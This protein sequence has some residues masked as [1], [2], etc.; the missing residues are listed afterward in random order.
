MSKT[1]LDCFHNMFPPVLAS[2]SCKIQTGHY[3]DSL[4]KRCVQCAQICGSHPAECSQYCQTLAPP[5]TFPVPSVL[6]DSSVL[7]YSLLALSIVLL[8]FSLSLALIVFLKGARAK[9]SNPGPKEANHNKDCVVQMGQ[10]VGRPDCQPG[11]SSK[12]FVTNSSCP[13]DR[14]PSDDPS[15]TET[16]VCVHCF[17]DLKT[18][19]QGNDRPPRAPLPFYSQSLLHRAQIQKNGSLWTEENIYSSGREVQE[20]AAEG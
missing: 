14:D 16:C 4:L 20:E 5:V 8:F 13:T 2:E 9:T 6:E 19:G 17:P 3:Y 7:L 1:S 11:Q 15:P 10:E 12:G 18:L